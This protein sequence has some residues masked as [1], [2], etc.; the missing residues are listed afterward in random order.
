MFRPIGQ[1]G[2]ERMVVF[3]ILS[4]G[5]VIQDG[6]D[7]VEIFGKNRRIKYGWIFCSR[8]ERGLCV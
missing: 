5:V 8:G 6:V 2:F 1:P 3:T 7:G 4:L